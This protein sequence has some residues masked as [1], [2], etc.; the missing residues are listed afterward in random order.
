M[1]TDTDTTEETTNDTQ[2]VQEQRLKDIEALA[3]ARDDWVGD[4]CV[5]LAQ[6]LKEE[7][8]S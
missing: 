3:E 1:S 2:T 4:L 5:A 8:T 7:R 6:S